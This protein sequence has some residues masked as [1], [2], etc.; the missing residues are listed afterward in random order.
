MTLGHWASEDVSFPVVKVAELEK[1]LTDAGVRYEFHRYQAQH[2]FANETADSKGLAFL[3][4][5][6]AVA[7]L[8]WSR[9]LDFLA[10]YLR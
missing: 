1:K 5:D 10:K 6:P 9:T 7:Q 4:C 8:A 2:A 3:K